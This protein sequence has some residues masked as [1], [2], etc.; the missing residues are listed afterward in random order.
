MVCMQSP[1]FP[2]C[3]LRAWSWLLIPS[4]ISHVSPPSSLRNSDAGSTPASR[5]FLP[6]PGSIDQMLARARPSPGGDDGADFVSLKVLPMSV[7]LRTF[8]PKNELQLEA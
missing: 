3:H 1:P 8:M 5:S 6:A 4:T 7:D 2:G